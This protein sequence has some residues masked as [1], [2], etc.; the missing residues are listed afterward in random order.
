[1]AEPAPALAAT[2]DGPVPQV[3]VARGT[4]R[5]LVDR[6]FGLLTWG[7]VFSVTGIWVHSVVAAIAV[8][9]AT[10]S[11]VAVGLVAVAQFGPQIFLTPLSGTWADAGDVR[12]QLIVGRLLCLLGSGGLVLWYGLADPRG[13]ASAGAVLVGSFV[14]GLGFVVGG[15]AMQSIVPALVTR[16]ELPAAMTLNT[17]PGTIARVVGPALG[18]FVV[19]H[20]DVA[21][22]FAVAGA[23]HALFLVAILPVRVPA[24]APRAADTDY[25]VRAG[26][27]HV[28]GDRPLLLLL[29]AVTAIGL[30]SEPT[31]TL[32]PA[33]AEQLG[34]GAALVGNLST[35]FGVGAVLGLVALAVLRRAITTEW[36]VAL[37]LLSMT[38]GSVVTAAAQG[39]VPSLVGYGLVGAGFSIAATAVGTAVQLRVPEVLRG[40]VMALWMV[41]F[42]GSRPIAALA[43]GAVAD[44]VSVRGAIVVM[45]LAPLAALLVCRPATLRRLP[46]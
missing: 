26:L 22:G 3:I 35:A 37:G 11:A 28:L 25:S 21:A 36:F 9:T 6:D 12:R 23:G 20:L 2:A 46:A 13:W 44:L 10:G 29:L 4:M 14:I 18:A 16:E 42:V 7:K 8:Y 34:G 1:M 5:L 19:T 17:A 32:A 43:V 15:P 24:R 33:V 39:V 45:A 31:L 41:G 30:G 27:R 40:R 38:A